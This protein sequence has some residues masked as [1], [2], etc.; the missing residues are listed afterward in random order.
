MKGPVPYG[1][2]NRQNKRS[3]V[4]P[5]V[6]KIKWEKY[7][8]CE[9]YISI[10]HVYFTAVIYKKRKQKQKRK[11]ENTITYTHR[12]WK[13]NSLDKDLDAAMNPNKLANIRR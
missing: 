12:I 8:T 7:K 11:N 3:G 5:H 1:N 6:P 4:I 13:K 2:D 10:L 9:K